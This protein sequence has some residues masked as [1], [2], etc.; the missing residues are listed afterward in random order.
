[1]KSSVTV[2]I[3]ALLDADSRKLSQ[4]NDLRHLEIYECDK[5]SN[6]K[7]GGLSA[8]GIAEYFTQSSPP[9]KTCKVMS[10]LSR[11]RDHGFDSGAGYS[12]EG[13]HGL[14]IFSLMSK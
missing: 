6:L 1:M 5:C 11:P 7:I 14:R 13:F 9:V 4:I 8:D 10:M 3:P 2:S 12:N